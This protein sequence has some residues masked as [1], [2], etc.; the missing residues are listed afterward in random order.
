MTE[1]TEITRTGILTIGVTSQNRRSVTEHPGRCRRFWIY[2]TRD[3]QITDRELIELTKEQTLHATAPEISAPLQQL[4][5]LLVADMGPGLAR[6]LADRG[7]RVSAS[8]EKEPEA[9]VVTF[10]TAGNP[11]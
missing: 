7:I 6:R 3:G 2:H 1:A 4:D 10:L 11:E 9:A 5:V 8:M